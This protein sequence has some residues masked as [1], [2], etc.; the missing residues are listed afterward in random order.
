MKFP[1][2]EPWS[3]WARWRRAS[4]AGMRGL[5]RWSAPGWTSWLWARIIDCLCAFD[6]WISGCEEPCNLVLLRT[7]AVRSN[8]F[9]FLM[10]CYGQPGRSSQPIVV[11]NECVWITASYNGFAWGPRNILFSC[12]GRMLSHIFYSDG[13]GAAPS[14][15]TPSA[16]SSSPPRH[17]CRDS[18]TVVPSSLYTTWLPLPPTFG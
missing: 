7:P 11:M 6:R 12:E 5:Y 4:G 13:S 9:C 1:D 2:P 3:V 18:F 14:G 15:P 8:G 17:P 10:D 16:P